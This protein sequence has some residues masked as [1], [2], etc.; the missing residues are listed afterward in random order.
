M[1]NLKTKIAIAAL[2]LISSAALTANA[3]AATWAQAHPRRAEVNQRLANQN[4]RVAVGRAD[5]QLSRGQ[6]RALH[7]EDRTIRREERFDARLDGGHVTRAEK[8]SLNQQENAVSH[9][10]Y[11]ERH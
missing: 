8:R 1:V 11:N 10:I 7:A 3:S 6:A 2:G 5:G 4:A 9:Q